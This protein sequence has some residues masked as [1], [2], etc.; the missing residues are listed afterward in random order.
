MSLRFIEPALSLQRSGRWASLARVALCS[1]LIAASSARVSNA[2]AEPSAQDRASARS[3]AEEGQKKLDEKDYKTALDLLSRADSLV[4]APT[5]KVRIAKAR[6]GLGQLLEAYELLMAVSREPP[7]AGDP[8]HYAKARKDAGDDAAKIYER[9]GTLTIKVP[10]DVTQPTV[11][12][13]GNALASVLVGVPAKF[14]AP[15]NTS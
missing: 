11:K 8:P 15:A 10:A 12:V 6:E 9:L 14:N 2:W 4:P 5:V 1:A 7:N 3:L 13:D